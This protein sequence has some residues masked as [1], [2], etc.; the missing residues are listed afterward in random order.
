MEGLVLS[1]IGVIVLLSAHKYIGKFAFVLYFSVF[2]IGVF[3]VA[4]WL[5]MDPKVLLVSVLGTALAGFL[6]LALWGY[7]NQ[8][9]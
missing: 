8:R 9:K 1:L 5:E 4:E 7:L 3:K 2:A 6:G